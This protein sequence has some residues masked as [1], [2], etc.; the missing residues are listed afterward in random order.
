MVERQAGRG[1]VGQLVVLIR[2]GVVFLVAMV[3]AG[4]PAAQPPPPAADLASPEAALRSYWGLLD[5]REQALR[6]RGPVDPTEAAYHRQM[7]EITAGRT[8]QFYQSV[9]SL[10]Q[11]RRRTRLE[12]RIISHMQES[13][14]RAV[15]VANIRNVT[16]VP[17]GAK[18]SAA[19]VRQRKKGEDFRYV[20]ALDATQW[21][22]LEVWSLS[23]GPRL[24]YAPSAA[25]Y[26]AFVPPQ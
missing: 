16:P 20:L 6:E 5:W 8:R 12:R 17:K 3:A 11:A 26:P 22:V 14:Q 2:P 7:M 1:V 24:L 25:E 18:P 13:P 19:L 23:M 10:I 21:K 15:I 4:S 9:Q